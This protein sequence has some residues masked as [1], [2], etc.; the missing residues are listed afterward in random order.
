ML[1]EIKSYFT[2][3]PIWGFLFQG[4]R[5]A[6]V[7][8]SGPGA[9][10][11]FVV[12]E[13]NMATRAEIIHKLIEPVV[14]ALGLQLWGIEYLG[15]G[16]HSLLRIYLDKQNGINI[17]D[18]AEASRQISSLLDVEDPIASEYT[19]EVSSPGLDRILF[20][21][22]QFQEYIGSQVKVRLTES[23]AGRRNYSGLIK[24]IKD[25]EIVLSDGSNEVVFPYELVEKANIVIDK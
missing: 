9:H 6:R 13:Q 1:G 17:D 8:R 16:R 19:L 25:G 21:L 14:L 20:T 24:Q 2:K 4:I 12:P 10:F 23:L 3:A 5:E 7:V 11:L 22:L 18:C 15:Q